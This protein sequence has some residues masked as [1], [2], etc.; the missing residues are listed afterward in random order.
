MNLSANTQ[1]WLDRMRSEIDGLPAGE[2]T[3]VATMYLAEAE[4]ALGQ[5]E[6]ARGTLARTVARFDFLHPGNWTS[7]VDRAAELC[8]Q[9]GENQLLGTELLRGLAWLAQPEIV[10]YQTRLPDCV[11]DIAIQVGRADVATKLTSHEWPGLCA[12]FASHCPARD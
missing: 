2:R 1:R 3:V 7:L 6:A 8:G 11:R 9:L 4:Y 5:L 12:E 10:K